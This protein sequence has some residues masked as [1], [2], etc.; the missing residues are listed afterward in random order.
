MILTDGIHIASDFS[1]LELHAF[2]KAAGLKKCW[3]HWNQRHSHYDKPKGYPVAALLAVGAI[4]VASK[5]L[6]KRCFQRQTG[7]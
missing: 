5:E 4:R 2:A 6:V 3:F 7:W 1:V